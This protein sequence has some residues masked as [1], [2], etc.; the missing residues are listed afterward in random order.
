[1]GLYELENLQYADIQFY[2][3]EIVA[4]LEFLH[5]RGVAHR[6]VKPENILL[7]PTRHLKM[8][9]FGTASVF[10]ES[11]MQPEIFERIRDIRN[12]YKPDDRPK[13]ELFG[14][15]DDKK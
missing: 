3:A 15:E 13:E 7:T 4:I 10:D 2:V 8:I 9:D 1:M 12:R 14:R 5:S 6:D 11:R